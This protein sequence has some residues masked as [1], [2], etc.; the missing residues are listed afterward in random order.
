MT[1]LAIS[2]TRKSKLKLFMVVDFNNETIL[3]FYPFW[4]MQVQLV[5]TI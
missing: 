3:I 5:T 2:L 1:K 4:T